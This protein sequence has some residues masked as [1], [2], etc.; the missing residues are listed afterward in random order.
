MKE[1]VIAI[2]K[3]SCIHEIGRKYTAVYLANA[4]FYITEEEKRKAEH[5]W[6]AVSPNQFNNGNANT[7]IL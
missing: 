5:W 4:I 7:E 2:I 1:N 6:E 3:L